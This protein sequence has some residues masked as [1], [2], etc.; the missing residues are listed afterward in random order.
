[1]INRNKLRGLMATKGIRQS[2][3]AKELDL[4]YNS[5]NMKLNGKNLFTEVEIKKIADYFNVDINF[6]FDY[7][8][9]D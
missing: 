9:V 8:A 1:M 6:L 3:L 5:F 4:S 2:E 7:N